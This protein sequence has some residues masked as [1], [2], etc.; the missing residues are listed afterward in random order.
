MKR[1]PPVKTVKY[2]V[3]A[4]KNPILLKRAIEGLINDIHSFCVNCS[5]R[6]R[7]RGKDY[8]RGYSTNKPHCELLEYFRKFKFN[9]REYKEREIKNEN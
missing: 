9:F 2:A 6:T 3:P 5:W 7:E 8:C 4:S 1:R